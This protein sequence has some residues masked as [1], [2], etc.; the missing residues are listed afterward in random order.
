MGRIPTKRIWN[1]KPVKPDDTK[2]SFGSLS[3]NYALFSILNVTKQ[4]L[5]VDTLNL[6]VANVMADSNTW[7]IQ[8]KQGNAICY[9]DR[10]NH[11]LA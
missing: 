2:Q 5:I 8:V 11:A 7:M 4:P 1:L 3:P 9:S 6:S 10:G